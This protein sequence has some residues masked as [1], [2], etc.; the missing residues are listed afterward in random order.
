MV[1]LS[2]TPEEV[3]GRAR[4]ELIHPTPPMAVLDS[5]VPLQVFPITGAE[6]EEVLPTVPVP[7]AMEV[8]AEVV[9]VLSVLPQEVLA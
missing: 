3:L 1:D 4:T 6:A 8:M 2:I 7:E 5:S 9:V